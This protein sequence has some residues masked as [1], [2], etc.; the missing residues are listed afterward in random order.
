MHHPVLIAGRDCTAA[1][2]LFVCDQCGADFGR[3]QAKELAH[4]CPEQSPVAPPFVPHTPPP[5]ASPPPV[6]QSFATPAAPPPWPTCG[7]G[8]QLTRLLKELGIE[9]GDGCGCTSRAA[10]LDH[11]AISIEALLAD[12][13]R[14]AEQRGLKFSESQVRWLIELA[15]M[16]A[17]ENREPTRL[18]RIRLRAIRIANRLVNAGTT[19]E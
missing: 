14:E 12:M 19:S 9:A 10:A 6:A 5:V 4:V 16:L 2:C 1:D 8:C 17:K 15:Q 13:R 18:E 7:P 3:H 11:G